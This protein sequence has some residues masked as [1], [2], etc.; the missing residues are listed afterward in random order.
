LKLS[1]RT[2]VSNIDEQSELFEGDGNE[3]ADATPF[4]FVVYLESVDVFHLL[5]VGKAR[6]Q[7]SIERQAQGSL[8]A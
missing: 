1:V 7:N 2:S 8:D 6:A 5:C 3:K 4:Q